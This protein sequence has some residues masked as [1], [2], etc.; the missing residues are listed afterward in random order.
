M[1]KSQFIIAVAEK[2]EVSAKQAE[3]VYGAMVDVILEEL[4][5]GNEVSLSPKFGTFKTSV[6]SART[7]R[8]PK[9]GEPIAVPEKTVPKLSFSKGFKEAVIEA[10]K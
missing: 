3:K 5:E 6:Q 1:N 4:K 7:A 8:N 9:T 2:A 10:H